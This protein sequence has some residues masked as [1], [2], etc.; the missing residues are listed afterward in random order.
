VA[1]VEDRRNACRALVGNLWEGDH[2]EDLGIRGRL[3][4]KWIV[5]KWDRGWGGGSA[6][7]WGHVNA[8]MNLR[9]P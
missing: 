1:S 8:I 6:P 7:G 9:V 5:K 4:L 2:F 3:I